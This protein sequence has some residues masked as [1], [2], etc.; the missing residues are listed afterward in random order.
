M[1]VRTIRT[2]KENTNSGG[3]E[4]ATASVVTAT[5]RHGFSGGHLAPISIATVS[6]TAICVF[7][8]ICI[9]VTDR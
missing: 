1:A 9:F 6:R 5:D 8:F 7:F 2:K 4:T 3:P